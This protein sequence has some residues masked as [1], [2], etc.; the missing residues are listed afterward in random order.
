MAA[1]KSANLC[2]GQRYVWLSHHHLPPQAR[3]DAHIVLDHPLPEGIG[4]A[5]IRNVLNYLVR[6]HEA[7]RTTYHLDA[8][9]WPEQ[10]V[11]PPA[12]VAVHQVTTESDGTPSPAEVVRN[13]TVTD[14][15][16]STEWPIRAC[17][18]TTGGVPRRLV[19]VLNHIAFDDWSIDTLKR[20]FE[21]VLTAVLARRPASLPPVS[22][23]PADLARY[24]ATQHAGQRDEA[25]AYWRRE[26]AELPAD[27]FARRRGTTTGT[28]EAY[29]A[30]LTSPRLLAAAR[31]IA[32]RH[33]VWPSVVHL[34]GYVLAMSA[35][36]GEPRITHGSFTSTREGGAHMDVMT[37]MFSPTLV[38]VDLSGDPTFGEVLRRTA[39]R[40]QRAQAHSSLPYDEV[41]ELLAQESHRRGQPLRTGSE[42]NFLNYAPR[43]CG[44]RRLRF[45]WNAA[46][47]AWAQGHSDTY[48]RVYEWQDGVTV[49]LQAMDT[50]MRADD[51]ERFLRGYEDLVSAHADAAL[52]VRVSE[53]AAR[54]GFGAP[55]ADRLVRVGHDLVDP[56]AVEAVLAAH[57]AVRVVE[58][59]EPERGLVAD[60]VADRPVSPGELRTHVLGA[61]YDHPSVRCPARFRVRYGDASTEGDGVPHAVVEGDAGSVATTDAEQA[62]VAVVGKVNGLDDVDPS[63][64]Y[65]VAGGRALR[66]PRVV[67]ELRAQ[68]W[69]GLSVYQLNSARPLRTLAAGLT[70]LD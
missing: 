34:A 24:E 62:L 45:A 11:H 66:A 51:V 19:L 29:S 2:F 3:H 36:T 67:A 14:F 69:G 42:V 40:V 43:S 53:V 68:G 20:E 28:P 6:R 7:L 25:L 22:A 26:I 58:V 59:G 17:V 30:S 23:Q 57:P 27:M 32:A 65:P 5:G 35:Y 38:T 4:L 44:T 31:D 70:P 64:S 55:G 60:V 9:P 52:D 15:D 13:L 63:D 49:A 1:V 61:M 8:D 50:V 39:E 16:L 41:V 48:F 10:R 21:A 54:I 37:C 12:P 46:P 33:K 18:V 47:T 56:Q